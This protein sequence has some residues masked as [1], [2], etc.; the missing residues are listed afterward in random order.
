MT[1]SLLVATSVL[2]LS[3]ACSAPGSSGGP[4]GGDI[5]SDGGVINTGG[6]NCTCD[7]TNGCTDCDNGTICEMSGACTTPKYTAN[8]DGTV[9]D[10]VT[11]L[12]WQQ[13]VPMTPCP[14]DGNPLCIQPTAVTYCQ[15]LSLGGQS[16]GWRLPT[17]PELFSIVD[18][19]SDPPMVDTT[20]FT[21]TPTD[22]PFWTS[23]ATGGGAWAVYFEAG[24]SEGL[25]LGAPSYVRCVR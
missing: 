9:T 2:A 22:K 7:T 24:L 14:L 10:N 12:I 13:S 20:V 18:V 25:D 16:T 5:A 23:S 19:A 6:N 17:L 4:D 3:A 1:R 11:G 8:G 15:G 21:S